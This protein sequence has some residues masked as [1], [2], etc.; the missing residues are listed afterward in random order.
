M[1]FV[2]SC[3]A[4]ATSQVAFTQA[5]AI[6]M[7]DFPEDYIPFFD[8]HVGE[9][10]TLGPFSDLATG[11]PVKIGTDL[12]QIDLGVAASMLPANFFQFSMSLK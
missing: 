9:S 8:F 11:D 5:G 1:R 2:R 4:A 12:Y 3:L 7:I 6:G 10:N